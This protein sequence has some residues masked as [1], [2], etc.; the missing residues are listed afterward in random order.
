MGTL[1]GLFGALVGTSVGGYVM[2]RY[3]SVILYR[4]AACTILGAYVLYGCL[5]MVEKGTWSF[6]AY[7]RARRRSSVK[8]HG[9]AD[10]DISDKE[11]ASEGTS[12][13]DAAG[14]AECE[15]RAG[16]VYSPITAVVGTQANG[17]EGLRQLS[18]STETAVNKGST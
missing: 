3:G 8:M 13:H 2:D 14:R 12:A 5:F 9:Q 7:F 15:D 1:T 17:D 18:A 4:G 16:A 6:F 11:P 10:E